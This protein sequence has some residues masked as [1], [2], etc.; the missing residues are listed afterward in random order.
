MLY[1]CL[2]VD[3]EEFARIFIVDPDTVSF[4]RVEQ[5]YR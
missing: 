5:L 3:D 1:Y 2:S 4:R